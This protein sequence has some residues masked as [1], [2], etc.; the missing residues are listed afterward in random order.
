MMHGSRSQVAMY[1]PANEL[2]LRVPKP[3]AQ[4]PATH[5][6]QNVNEQL[7]TFKTSQAQKFLPQVAKSHSQMPTLQP[8]MSQPTNLA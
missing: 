8:S 6:A 5:W 4:E 7:S 2:K 3:S 1:T